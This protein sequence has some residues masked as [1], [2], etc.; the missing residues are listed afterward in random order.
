MLFGDIDFILVIYKHKSLSGFYVCT[1]YFFFLIENETF[2]FYTKEE[3][4]L[5]CL[6]LFVL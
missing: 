3:K 6:V 5:F 4:V 2:Y 1:I